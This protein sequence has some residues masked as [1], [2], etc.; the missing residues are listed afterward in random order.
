VAVDVLVR[1][2]EG[3]EDIGLRL[4]RQI[5]VDAELLDQTVDHAVK[6]ARFE[7]EQKNA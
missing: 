7:I 2:E 3:P 6:V 4:G 5:V 1:Q